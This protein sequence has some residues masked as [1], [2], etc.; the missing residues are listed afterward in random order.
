M[1][2]N[3][4]RRPHPPPFQTAQ[5]LLPVTAL[6]TLRISNKS[7]LLSGQGSFLEIFDL[8]SKRRLLRNRVFH[9]RS[10]HGIACTEPT[11]QNRA[12]STLLI[13]GA[14]SLCFVE[15]VAECPS[16]ET[17]DNTSRPHNDI[18]FEIR[19]Q[20]DAQ[21]WILDASFTAFRPDSAYAC[22]VTSHNSVLEL[23]R[24]A[25]SKES[26]SVVLH[27]ISLQ[28]LPSIS[29]DLSVISACKRN[30]STALKPLLYSARLKVLSS[31]SILVAAGTVFGE[32]LLWSYHLRH[33]TSDPLLRPLTPPR[34]YTGHEGSIFGVDISDTFWSGNE[35]NRFLAS[36]GDDR[37][38][39][40]AVIDEKASHATQPHVRSVGGQEPCPSVEITSNS[41]EEIDPALDV[42]T[43]VVD[44]W[45][46]SSRVWNVKFPTAST[47]KPV[48]H[49][50]AKSVPARFPY[51]LSVGEDA[52][53]QL[54]QVHTVDSMQTI[55]QRSNHTSIIGNNYGDVSQQ[56]IGP[57]K[58]VQS[59][60]YHLGKNIWSLATHEISEDIEIFT[61]GADGRIVSRT[62]RTPDKVANGIA[63]AAVGL[64][65]ERE[66]G[67]AKVDSEHENSEGLRLPFAEIF[68]SQD[69]G[70]IAQFPKQC[71]AAIKQYLFVSHTSLLALT[72]SGHLLR[73]DLSINSSHS[74]ESP[75]S[76]LHWKALHGGKSFGRRPVLS[77]NSRDEVA[78]LGT[79]NG[80]L[81]VYK[82]REVF[83]QLP[84]LSKLQ[85]SWLSIAG[86]GSQRARFSDDPTSSIP[87]TTHDESMA[88]IERYCVIGYSDREKTA[89]VMWLRP[90]ST[91]N[92]SYALELPDGFVP[93][94]AR[95]MPH[96]GALVL[97]SRKGALAMYRPNSYR[98]PF[99]VRRVHSEDGLTSIIEVRFQGRRQNLNE[100]HFLTTGRE[101]SY[102]I[103]KIDIGD[104]GGAISF[105]TLDMSTAH[106]GSG[107]EGAYFV[108]NLT[109]MQMAKHGPRS[110]GTS[111]NIPGLL[112]SRDLMMYGFRSTKFIVWNETR[113]TQVFEA[114]CAG[115]H[116][117]W[118]FNEHS[119]SSRAETLSH[120]GLL[121]WT[122]ARS[123]NLSSVD[124]PSNSELQQGGHGREIKALSVSPK[125]Y[126]D[127]SR[128]I[129][130]GGLIAT[131]AE[132]TTIRLFVTP[133]E[134][135]ATT[136]KFPNDYSES[137]E[138][139]K[140]LKRHTTGL[141]HLAFSTC[142]RYL[143]S[144]GGCEELFVWRVTH[145]VPL[146][147]VG[148]VLDCAFPKQSADSDLRITDFDFIEG[149]SNQATTCESGRIFRVAAVYSNSMIRVFHYTTATK[150]AKATC[151][152]I[153]QLA[154]KTN[155]LTQVHVSHGTFTAST[156]G[157]IAFWNS[158]DK[159]PRSF[160]VDIAD[161]SLEGFRLDE[162]LPFVHPVHQNSI[163]TFRSVELT[164][165]DRILIT[166]G[167]DNAIALTLMRTPSPPDR[168]L[169]NFN[170]L[171]VPQAHAAAVTAICI[172]EGPR[173]AEFQF[174]STGNDQRVILWRVTVEIDKLLSTGVAGNDLMDAVQLHKIHQTVTDVADASALELVPD[175]APTATEKETTP[176]NCKVLVVGIGMEVLQFEYE[177]ATTSSQGTG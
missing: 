96:S 166:G 148:I 60:R 68:G 9:A 24:A 12:S 173:P 33:S 55:V 93:T 87:A 130:N 116:R 7:L 134:N 118:T 3:Q 101:G 49:H 65:Q 110:H 137:M 16:A 44:A 167:D 138:C 141:Q 88:F 95:L 36:C 58:H 81:F 13:W 34:I 59:D 160:P 80:D 100:D 114:D 105:E 17:S 14:S 171:L 120:R 48:V 21:D 46:H 97:G 37:S 123:F 52:A 109:W 102:A 25:S 121:A 74:L 133:S 177:F 150:D 165:R 108:D 42:S 86:I 147:G 139:I 99:C 92:T 94:C 113:R 174:L 69:L 168:N 132:D 107:I 28:Q 143:F 154:Y 45:N 126:S 53:C 117:S 131:G 62:A 31:A 103:H 129:I 63:G 50:H 56:A 4:P 66:N 75:P 161:N 64:Y 115:S 91:E 145:N 8:E 127:S 153:Q 70:G 32:V 39:R 18:Q 106:T 176:R 169:P 90:M 170:T 152:L 54:W 162:G 84:T 71:P 119:P 77:T 89:E 151:D 47:D 38:V 159:T 85:V 19:A 111:T 5:H 6:L 78:F 135:E 72:D 20:Y 40:I 142:G 155:C 112:P 79:S 83:P 76:P 51:L 175:F 128:G 149:G 144:S 11:P 82:G 23:H 10:V 67:S 125:T 73:A 98:F 26:A 35:Q 164:S 30:V 140:V 158:V 146:V 104:G 15:L 41:Y 29:K 157:Y 22:L 43:K 163:K 61:G 156:D 57:P 136:T 1:D 27:Q 124:V 2:S 122:Q 172:L